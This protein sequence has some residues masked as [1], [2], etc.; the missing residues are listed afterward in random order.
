MQYK[1]IVSTAERK[2][3]EN[4]RELLLKTNIYNS[5]EIMNVSQIKEVCDECVNKY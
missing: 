2:T 3:A 5:Q 4:V 1:I